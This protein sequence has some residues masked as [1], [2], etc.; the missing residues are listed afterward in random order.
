LVL[1]NGLRIHVDDLIATF[2][3]DQPNW[4]RNDRQM[5]RFIHIGY[6]R[7]PQVLLKLHPLIDIFE[8]RIELGDRW[9][10]SSDFVVGIKIAQRHVLAQMLPHDV[11]L[12]VRSPVF[13]LD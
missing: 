12:L 11:A 8:L 3:S 10:A 2:K 4:L 9:K 13:D 1:A 7:V 5:R 6:L